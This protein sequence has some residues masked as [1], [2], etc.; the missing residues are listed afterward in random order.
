MVG[1]HGKHLTKV[2]ESETHC[3]PVVFMF[4]SRLGIGNDG[5]SII[6]TAL[7]VNI[8]P[9]AGGTGYMCGQGLGCTHCHVVCRRHIS[10]QHCLYPQSLWWMVV[11]M[12]CLPSVHKIKLVLTHLMA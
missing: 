11:A 7:P 5:K 9:S 8:V 12:T 2:V 4:S 6:G 10:T 1:Y 3:V